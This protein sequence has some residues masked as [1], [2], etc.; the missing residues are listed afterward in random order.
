MTF[1]LKKKKTVSPIQVAR[2]QT[3]DTLPWN[4][5]FGRKIWNRNGLR[6][7][8]S[9][10][11][12]SAHRKKP[13]WKQDRA[14]GITSELFYK[15]HKTGLPLFKHPQWKALNRLLSERW[16]PFLSWLCSV[17][18]SAAVSMAGFIPFT[19][20]AFPRSPSTHFSPPLPFLRTPLRLLFTLAWLRG[21]VLHYS[22][23]Q[24][25]PRCKSLVSV[26]FPLPT[27]P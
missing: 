26:N 12:T 24:C 23:L 4:T 16:V 6:R 8:C 22:R 27:G 18:S 20:N 13:P 1:Y 19:K 14:T 11:L 15:R 2:W 21:S 3:V 17:F 25:L 5:T 7:G 9:T 10:N